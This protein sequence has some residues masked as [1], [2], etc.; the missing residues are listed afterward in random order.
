MG[1]RARLVT[2]GNLEDH[3]D[4]LEDV[5]WVLE[6]IIERLDIKQS[7]FEKITPHLKPEAILSSNTSGLSIHEMAAG[8]PEDLRPRFLGTHFFNPP[9]YMKLLEII[10]HQDTH[11]DVMGCQAELQ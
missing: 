2:P 11:P 5:D 6:A 3:L 7:V 10:P 4:L 1:E 9:R 8:L